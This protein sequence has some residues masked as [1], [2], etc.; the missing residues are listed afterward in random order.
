[1]RT[2]SDLADKKYQDFRVFN[3]MRDNKEL[4]KHYDIMQDIYIFNDEDKKDYLEVC[5]ALSEINK[6]LCSLN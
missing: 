3:E 6:I 4:V 2:G 1:V 5:D